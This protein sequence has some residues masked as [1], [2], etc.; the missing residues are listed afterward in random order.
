MYFVTLDKFPDISTFR[1]QVS[2][3]IV[4]Y[5]RKK[6][7]VKAFFLDI[8]FTTSIAGKIKH[9]NKKWKMLLQFEAILQKKLINMTSL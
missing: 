5:K 2:Y 6:N 4:S 8:S 1:V 9:D 7:V 3:K